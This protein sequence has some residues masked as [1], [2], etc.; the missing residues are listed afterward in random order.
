MARSVLVLAVLVLACQT[1]E[2]PAEIDDAEI[3][4]HLLELIVLYGVLADIHQEAAAAARSE[5][6][7]RMRE[8]AEREAEI[9]PRVYGHQMQ[10]CPYGSEAFRYPAGNASPIAFTRGYWRRDDSFPPGVAEPFADRLDD[11][12]EDYRSAADMA[13]R[14]L[15]SGNPSC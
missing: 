10:V 5:D 1:S 6:L 9:L 13:S 2:P 4:G 7:E 3:A 8:A 14:W 15:S 12:A 11:F